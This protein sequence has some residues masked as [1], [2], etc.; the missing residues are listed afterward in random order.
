MNL[1]LDTH[2]LI[3]WATD[4][5]RLPNRCREVILNQENL[6]YFSSLSIWEVAIKY[7]KGLIPLPSMLLYEEALSAGLLEAPFT[8][9]HAARVEQLPEIHQDPFDRGLIAQ[10]LDFPF[11][12]VSQDKKLRKYPAQ[13]LH[14]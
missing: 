11:T 9:R 1:L 7:G 14:F 2:I 5:N 13:I 12:L 6:V 4:S 8:A 10:A 3:W